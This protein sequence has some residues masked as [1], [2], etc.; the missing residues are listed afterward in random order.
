ML[1]VGRD[2]CGSVSDDFK[3]FLSIPGEKRH[4]FSLA[5]LVV[6]VAALNPCMAVLPCHAGREEY[7]L[8][9]AVSSETL[10]SLRSRTEVWFCLRSLLPCPPKRKI[11]FAETLWVAT[12]VGFSG[13]QW[14]VWVLLSCHRPR[15]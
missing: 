3:G 2:L 7:F 4:F 10:Y 13:D 15:S 8:L 11:P 1:G 12:S 14:N 9:Q 5:V 6:C